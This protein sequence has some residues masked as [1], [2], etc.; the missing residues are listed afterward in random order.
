MFSA[1]RIN[2]KGFPHHI[3]LKDE[4]SDTY[5][6]I[7]LNLGGSLQE[8]TLSGKQIIKDLHPF[9]YKTSFASSILF[10]FV[11]RIENGAYMFNNHNYQMEVN[12]PEEN[13]ALHGLVFDKTFEL[14]NQESSSD[15]ASVSIILRE[16]ER[17]NG[18]PFLYEIHLTYRLDSVSLRLIATVKN[19]DSV[20]FPFSLGWHPYFHSN[21]LYKS[22]LSINYEV[23]SLNNQDGFRFKKDEV[24]FLE[25]F[26]IMDN[27]LD[28]CYFLKTNKIGFNTPDYDIS[29]SVSSTDT[30]L[31][32]YTPPIR[33]ALAIELQTSPANSFNTKIGLQIL[34]PNDSFEMSWKIELN[35]TN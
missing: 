13:H 35:Q 11:N 10:P 9:E 2:H 26:Q 32:L 17:S 16:N 7:D 31:Q 6:K 30:Y 3:V 23:T 21:D 34:Q 29:V 20:A 1:D 12:D 18:Y 14:E 25:N 8:L 19:I 27:Q 22:R 28:D 4:S 5:A 24:D 33:N 15:S